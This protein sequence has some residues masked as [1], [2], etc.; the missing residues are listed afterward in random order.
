MNKKLKAKDYV[1]VFISMALLVIFDQVTKLLAYAYLKDSESIVLISDVFQLQYLENRGAAFGIFQNQRMMFI[2]LTLAILVTAGYF[3][4][5]IPRSARFLPMFICM[6][7]IC[8]GAIGNFIDR[9]F[10]GFVVDF[11]YF[12]LIDFPIFNV[13]DIYIT[14]GFAIVTI[15]V[16]G[17]YTE[18]ELQ[19]ISGEKVMKH[20][21]PGEKGK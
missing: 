18:E 10:R 12:S 17:H 20:E 16:F 8:A 2:V 11:F 15:L 21:V 7:A 9:L 14:V 5:H 1:I 3:F 19:I 6:I 4:V 13:A